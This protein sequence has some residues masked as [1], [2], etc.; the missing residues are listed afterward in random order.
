MNVQQQRQSWVEEYVAMGGSRLQAD[1]LAYRQFPD[2]F[3]SPAHVQSVETPKVIVRSNL[4]AGQDGQVSAEQVAEQA[5][6]SKIITAE[7]A[8]DLF[9]ETQRQISK[10]TNIAGRL[11]AAQRPGRKPAPLMAKPPTQQELELFELSM[12]LDEKH[13]R[14]T[15]SLGF[16]PSAMILASLP[17]S[18][19][20]GAIFKRKNNNT[21]LTIMNNPDI[22]LPYGKIPRVIIA[23]LCTEARRNQDTLGPEIFL[24]R[25][26]REF[27]MKLGMIGTGG[28]NGDLGR[29]YDQAKRLFTSSIQLTG[30][31]GTQFHWKKMDITKSGMLLWNP[32][33]IT[34]E[35]PWESKLRLSDEFFEEC[36]NHSF[37]FH[38]KVINKFKSPL[39][40]DIYLWLTY[41]YNGLSTQMHIS[42]RQLQWQ[43]GCSYADT[44]QGMADFKANFKK[45]LRSVL[46][47]YRNANLDTTQDTLILKPSKPHIDPKAIP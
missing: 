18:K 21:T 3:T 20:D 8:P 17:H 32:A 44:P 2:E 46:A 23:F 4:F 42:W 5:I 11:P 41:R 33:D 38:L 28:K 13:A 1:K 10:R 29:T 47:V 16:M 25:S 7:S 31:P 35:A 34:E 27:M 26:Q 39:A 19:V 36:R 30:E 12:E 43:F 14:D 45:Q 15:D 37:P 22:G 9:G 6:P 24:G 40:I